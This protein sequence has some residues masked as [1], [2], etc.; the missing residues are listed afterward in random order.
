MITSDHGNIEN[1]T[2]PFT[3]LPQTKHDPSLVPFS[4]IGEAFKS[5]KSDAELNLLE[6]EA[7]G[8]LS[9][10]APTVLE[11]LNLPKPESMT[12]QSLLKLLR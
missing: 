6:N 5:R 10:V 9:D 12:G 2:D 7:T 8:I 4:L 11:L 3:G 1:M